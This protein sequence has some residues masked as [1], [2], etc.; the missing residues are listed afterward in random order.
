MIDKV[1]DM[2]SQYPA[3]YLPFD[4]NR[5]VQQK[6]IGTNLL[7]EQIARQS[8]MCKFTDDCDFK[9]Y[10]V[11]KKSFGLRVKGKCEICGEE[12]AG[13]QEVK[14]TPVDD[15]IDTTKS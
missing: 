1:H 7:K 12:I 2:I 8:S 15:T 14:S 9:S 3:E 6:I 10:L 5:K 13:L 11:A 4:I